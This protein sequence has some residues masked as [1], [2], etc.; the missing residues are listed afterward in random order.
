MVFPSFLP[1]KIPHHGFHG[2]GMS[3]HAQK[4][5][6]WQNMTGNWAVI[7]GYPAKESY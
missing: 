4:I 7:A 6:T 3:I 5:V 2:G 1:D